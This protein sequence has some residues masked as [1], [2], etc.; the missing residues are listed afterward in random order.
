MVSPDWRKILFT[1]GDRYVD[2]YQALLVGAEGI[3]QSD[4][5]FYESVVAS[6]SGFDLDEP[7]VE[8]SDEEGEDDSEAAILRR[9][10]KTEQANALEY[11]Q[12]YV[13]KPGRIAKVTYSHRRTGSAS[14]DPY[15]I[16]VRGF[17]TS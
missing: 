15:E 4:L 11:Y 5:D 1:D 10:G 12:S 13:S 17:E 14:L 6:A 8:S 3:E 2:Q 7:Y 16:W 9:N